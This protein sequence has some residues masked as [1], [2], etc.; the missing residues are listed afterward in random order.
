MVTKKEIVCYNTDASRLVGK[1]VKVVFPKTIEAVQRIIKTND[2]D[3]VPRGAGTEK[4]GGVIPNNSIIVDMS[5]MCDVSE[6][7]VVKKTVRVQAGLTINELNERLNKINFEFPIQ[8]N[9]QG[10]SSIGGMIAL[11]SQGNKGMKYGAIK[12]LIEEIEFVNGRGELMKIS[13]AD[14][15]DICGMEGITGVIISA[16]LKIIPKIKRS[17]S[18]F[19]S[20]DISEIFSISRRL[21]LEKEICSLTLFPPQVSILLGLPEKYHLIVEFDSNRGKIRGGEYNVISNLSDKVYYN[22]ISEGYYGNEDPKF[23]FDKLKEFILFLESNN[24]PYFGKIGKGIIYPFFKDDEKEKREEVVQM[25]NRMAGKSGEYGIGI[26]RKYL[27]DNFE[28]KI[29]QRVKKRHD[30]FLKINKNKIIDLDFKADSFEKDKVKKEDVNVSHLKPIGKEEIEEIKSTL[31]NKDD[32][33]LIEEGKTPKEKMQEFIEKVELIDQTIGNN[34]KDESKD[35]SKNQEDLEIKTKLK[36]YESTYE[37][38]L[39]DEKKK[40]IEDFA[41]NIAQ[42]IIHPTRPV[43]I[44][45]FEIKKQEKVEDMSWGKASS[46]GD[47]KENKVEKQ[48]KEFKIDDPSVEKRGKLTSDEEDEINRVM[49]GG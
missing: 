39:V 35:E 6:F 25:I 38:E 22:F 33:E 31:D 18:I 30:P 26:T 4:A 49:F 20:E 45:N 17:A 10:I 5:K 42:D 27:K 36:D 32:F 1:A 47:K 41:K 23:F 11:N 12:E 28:K 44:K 40:T 43:E 29:I 15:G 19:Q 7:D 14:L 46:S 37:S 16:V 24:I 13:R 21:K 3:I 9:N 48:E 2:L 8:I 34:V